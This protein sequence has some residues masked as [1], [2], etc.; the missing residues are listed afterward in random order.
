MMRLTL[1]S[2]ALLSAGTSIAAKP[3][4]RVSIPAAFQG[5]WALDTR[6]CA[7]GPSDSGNMRISARKIWQFE[8]LAIIARVEIL[9][10]QTLRVESR[11]THNGGTFGSVEMMS[12][13][14]DRQRLTIG[15]MSD[16]SVYKRCGK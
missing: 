2:L 9:D 13:S 7:V 16:L 15:E 3:V 11:V 5:D 12:L 10:A 4:K 6:E 8:S 14:A 1:L